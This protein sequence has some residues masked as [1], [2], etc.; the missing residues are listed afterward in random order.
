MARGPHNIYQEEKKKKDFKN[1]TSDLPFF[2][3]LKNYTS[4][5]YKSQYYKPERALVSLP[6]ERTPKLHLPTH[7][8]QVNGDW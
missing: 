7:H 8:R 3:H 6:Q 2:N 5:P 1:L 4:S